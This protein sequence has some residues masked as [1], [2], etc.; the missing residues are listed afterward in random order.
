[1]SHAFSQKQKRSY[2]ATKSNS[3]ETKAV[4]EG[5]KIHQTPGS[6]LT[7]D[8]EKYI[9]ERT[10]SLRKQADSGVWMSESPCTYEE[11]LSEIDALRELLFSKSE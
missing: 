3:V 2:S 5:R 1:M 10:K 4:S 11:L 8:S 9:R 7:P 6:K